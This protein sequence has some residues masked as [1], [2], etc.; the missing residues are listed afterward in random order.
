MSAAIKRKGRLSAR[1]EEFKA[2]SGADKSRA[3]EYLLFNNAM[4]II[5]VIAIIYKANQVP[6]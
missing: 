2:K 1:L 3:I 4:Y 5:T 6:A